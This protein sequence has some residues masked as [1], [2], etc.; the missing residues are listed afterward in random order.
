MFSIVSNKGLFLCL[1]SYVFV[2]NDISVLFFFINNYSIISIEF[3]TSAKN[4]VCSRF[5]DAELY[6]LVWRII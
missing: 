3:V 1:F 6:N 4:D 5:Y 2:E